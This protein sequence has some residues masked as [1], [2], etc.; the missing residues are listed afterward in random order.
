MN[1]NCQVYYY[2]Y[3]I[4]QNLFCSAGRNTNREGVVSRRNNNGDFLNQLFY[5]NKFVF[6]DVLDSLFP[7]EKLMSFFC[8]ILYSLNALSKSLSKSCSL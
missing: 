7:A 8:L 1:Y 2:R 5:L 6:F 4:N 3:F